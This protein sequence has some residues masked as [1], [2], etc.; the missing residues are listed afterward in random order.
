MMKVLSF[1]CIL[2]AMS[3][4]VMAQ[5]QAL[6]Q[7]IDRMKAEIQGELSGTQK[8]CDMERDYNVSIIDGKR[9]GG[10]PQDREHTIT[11]WKEIESARQRHCKL[12]NEALRARLNHVEQICK[13]QT[14]TVGIQIISAT[15]GGNCGAAIGNATSHIS[16]HCNGKL[17]CNYTVDYRVIGDPSYGCEKTYLVQYRCNDNPNALDKSLS[18]EAGWGDKTVKLRCR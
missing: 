10:T 17:E 4:S 11:K 9:V 3:T 7:C 8:R 14:A 2:A 1:M 5:G 6:Q 18:A 16:S 12:R 15:Y 13:S